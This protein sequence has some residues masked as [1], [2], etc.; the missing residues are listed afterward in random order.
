M[1]RATLFGVL[2]YPGNK[3]RCVSVY[4]QYLKNVSCLFTLGL[5]QSSLWCMSY[6]ALLSF[7]SQPPHILLVYLLMDNSF[8]ELTPLRLICVLSVSFELSLV[9]SHL[10]YKSGWSYLY[11]HLCQFHKVRVFIKSD[12][13][14]PY[15]IVQSMTPPPLFTTDQFRMHAHHE[16]AALL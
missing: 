8:T 10:L 4:V 5:V 1:A 3:L 12:F 7:I 6:A 9:L 16:G 11:L 13:M 14:S 2:S 15:L